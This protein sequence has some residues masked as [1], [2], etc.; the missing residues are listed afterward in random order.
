VSAILPR[1]VLGTARIGSGASER[2]GVRLAESAFAAGICAVDTAPIY[3]LGLAERTVGLALRSY[4]D[5]RVTTKV[6]YPRPAFGYARSVL[7]R[8]KRGLGGSR[9]D[10]TQ[11]AE[12]P[13]PG[14]GDSYL[15]I[16]DEVLQAT[17][18]RSA[19]LL[20]RIDAL[21]LH[22]VTAASA[23]PD[24]LTELAQPYSAETGY[25]IAATWDPALD[26]IFPTG[27]I[28]Q[29]AFD[30]AWLA[31]VTA[32]PANRPLVLHSLVKAGAV[33]EHD[34]SAFAATLNCAAALVDH[35][36]PVAARIAALYALAAVRAPHA[37]LIVASS[38]HDRLTA[39]LAAIR[40][41]DADKLAP[42]I[43]ALFQPG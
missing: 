43:A 18:A 17:L 1:L 36:D 34:Q 42:E 12:L 14:L 38:H 8:I 7:R 21:L 41:I 20:G 29:C 4:P 40:A 35:P 13:Q 27:A 22:D 3:G 25:A 32:V 6:G 23:R 2:D 16:S 30:P 24:W 39:T 31:G 11:L 33:A 9:S 19:E 10:P 15:A 26:A 37:R 5:V 28:A